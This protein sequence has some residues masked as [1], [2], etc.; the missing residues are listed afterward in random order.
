MAGLTGLKLTEEPLLLPILAS[1]K[2]LQESETTC[3]PLYE[4]VSTDQE[5]RR[6]ELWTPAADAQ[7]NPEAS[8]GGGLLA[9]AAAAVF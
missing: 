4:A 3:R 2:A 9:A 7:C 6:Q 8:L 1:A 5:L